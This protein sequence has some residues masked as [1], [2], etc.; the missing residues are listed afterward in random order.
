MPRMQMTNI[1]VIVDTPIQQSYWLLGNFEQ[2]QVGKIECEGLGPIIS[3]TK[4]AVVS[5]AGGRV[6]KFSEF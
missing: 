1:A 5:I 6:G 3:S 2:M 4:Y